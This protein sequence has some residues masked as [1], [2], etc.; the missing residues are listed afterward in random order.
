MKILF[1]HGLESKPG[2]TKVKALL[3]AGHTVFNPLLPK[4]SFEES[5]RIAQEIVDHE[6][7]ACVVGSSRGGAVAM[8]IDSKDAKLVLIAPAWK[9]FNALPVVRKNTVILH[10]TQDNIVP[11]NDS[12]ELA[13][14][15]GATLEKCGECHRMH[16]DEAIDILKYYVNR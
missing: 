12:I 13:L 2:G 15:T 7:P 4:S 3:K 11:F 16:D 9:R 1:L 5:V 10:S 8:S 14:E 6:K